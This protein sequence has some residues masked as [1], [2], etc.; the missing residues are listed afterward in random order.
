MP[1]STLHLVRFAALTHGAIGAD[2]LCC[3]GPLD[4]RS[5]SNGRVRRV[6]TL[7]LAGQHD[8]RRRIPRRRRHPRFEALGSAPRPRSDRPRIALRPPGAGSALDRVLPTQSGKILRGRRSAA[9]P[10]PAL[11]APP[12]GRISAPHTGLAPLPFSPNPETGHHRR[13]SSPACK[14]AYGGG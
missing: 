4:I 12:H 3:A 9:G 13:E 2:L 8:E 1:S 5:V 6:D 11:A 14:Q 7:F 10:R